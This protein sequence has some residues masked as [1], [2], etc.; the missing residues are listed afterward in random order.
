MNILI[1][2]SCVSR[3]ALEF[4]TIKKINLKGYFARSSLASSMCDVNVT[5]ISTEKISS[6][7]QRRMVESDLSK[8]LHKVISK[9]EYDLLLLDFIDERFDLW[10]SPN[11]GVCTLSNELLQSGFVPPR[12]EIIKSGSELW[13]SYWESGW[14]TLLDTLNQTGQIKKLLINEVYWSEKT[15]NGSDYLPT[16]SKVGINAA[17]NTLKRIYERIKCDISEAQFIKFNTTELIGAESHKWGKSPFHYQDELYKKIVWRLYTQGVNN[18]D[19][20]IHS[21]PPFCDTLVLTSEKLSQFQIKI[22]KSLTTKLGLNIKT[23]KNFIIITNSDSQSANIVSGFGTSNEKTIST[24]SIDELNERDLFNGVGNY[25]ACLFVSEDKISFYQDYFGMGSTYYTSS[26]YV[27]LVSNRAHLAFIYANALGIKEPNVNNINSKA[28]EHFFFSGQAFNHDTPISGINKTPLNYRVDI[29]EHGLELIENQSQLGQKTLSYEEYLEKGIDEIKYITK[30]SLDI[31]AKNNPT[32]CCDLS[33]GKDSR[34]ALAVIMSVCDNKYY[35]RT[36]DVTSNDDL[37]IS[38]KIASY[39]DLK[40]IDSSHELCL[41]ISYKDGI[42]IWRSYFMGDYHRMGLPN[43]S[44]YGESQTIR[45]GGGAGEIYRDFWNK[46]INRSSSS[47]FTAVVNE[48]LE[49]ESSRLNKFTDEERQS[50]VSYIK[51][52]LTLEI[53]NKNSF[54]ALSE[55][56]L[57]FRNRSH[58]GMRHFTTFNDAV[59]VFP[60]LSPSLF[61]AALVL[62]ETDREN[63]RLMFDIIE[64]LQP[65]LNRFEYD[66]GFSIADSHFPEKISVSEELLSDKYNQWKDANLKLQ[67]SSPSTYRIM[68]EHNNLDELLDREVAA[69][70][71]R[72]KVSMQDSISLLDIMYDRYKKHRKTSSNLTRTTASVI[73]SIDD[74]LHPLQ[75]IKKQ[76]DE[77]GLEKYG[78]EF[79]NPIKGCEIIQDKGQ[80]RIKV[81][82][83]DDISNDDYLFAFYL[84][85]NGIRTHTIW[86][87][88]ETERT[89]DIEFDTDMSLSVFA[90]HKKSSRVFIEQ[91]D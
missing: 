3:D 62:N 23:K 49:T 11:G 24:L 51:N 29:T 9:A 67:T 50:M 4:D 69:S 53:S 42:D 21:P 77:I 45:I 12:N 89:I 76:V 70:L 39:Y 18:Y 59:Y 44:S 47:Y 8:E 75:S 73:F 46:I 60:L 6:S 32:I 79:F 27:S 61:K 31:L 13:F 78:N 83:K 41:P 52:T 28:L 15:V 74:A 20:F 34:A 55:H 48:L 68:A 57:K 1:Y 81:N 26:Q 14:I 19:G 82:I 86:Y 35:I 71:C 25:T 43:K 36:N 7:F 80:V 90:K 56:Y 16:Y 33:G 84:F 10:I 38:L 2:G 17:N 30:N 22:I 87:G 63:G 85:K 65:E 66:G 91:S 5:G 88:E 54:A 72:I 37:S 40:Y 64:R 58:F